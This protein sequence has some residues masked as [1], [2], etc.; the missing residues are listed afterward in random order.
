MPAIAAMRHNPVMAAFATRPPANGKRTKHL[1]DGVMKS[2][3]PF[4][5]AHLL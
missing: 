2:G 4:I 1:L 5:N 3:R